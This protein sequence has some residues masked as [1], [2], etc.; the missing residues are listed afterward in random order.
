MAADEPAGD[1]LTYG[2][3][4][5]ELETILTELDDE[6]IDVDVLADRVR[7]AAEL[8][9]ICRERIAGARL[10]IEQIVMDLDGE[11][12]ATGLADDADVEDR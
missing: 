12:D 5:V 7:R 1:E 3:A 4:V 8:I 6:T 9:R 10:E 11:Q 2:D